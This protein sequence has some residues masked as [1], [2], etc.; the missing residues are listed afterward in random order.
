[1]RAIRV[2][3]CFA[4]LVT[5]A[6][7]CSLRDLDYLSS[8]STGGADAGGSADGGGSD[9]ASDARGFCETQMD[10]SFCMD[11]DEAVLSG[12]RF[13]KRDPVAEFRATIDSPA[14]TLFVGDG[15]V[16]PPGALLSRVTPAGDDAGVNARYYSLPKPEIVAATKGA[17]LDFDL[18][19]DEGSASSASLTVVSVTLVLTDQREINATV[20]LAANP[21]FSLILQGNITGQTG[22]L[23]EASQSFPLG[24]SGTWTHVQVGIEVAVNGASLTLGVGG[25]LVGLP[26]VFPTGTVQGAKIDIGLLN[27]KKSGATVSVRLDNVVVVGR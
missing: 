11:F 9:S 7:A 4:A 16:S 20:A 19:L 8:G 21:T 14:G 17:T 5:I 2:L 22:S 3:V 18:R 25:Q 24:P 6:A 1:M 23:R 15:G 26:L 13:G 10:A 27:P 12:F